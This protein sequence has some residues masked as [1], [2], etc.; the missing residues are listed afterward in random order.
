MKLQPGKIQQ[1][2]KGGRGPAGLLRSTS[3][4]ISFRKHVVQLLF[5]RAA[6]PLIVEA[7]I[8]LGDSHGRRG[9][10]PLALHSIGC[11]GPIQASRS[12]GKEAYPQP[13]NRM[14]RSD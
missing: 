5:D 3:V 13:C 2:D 10:I 14:S 9:E 7:L 6:E 1:A 8:V 4:R 11:L 12:R